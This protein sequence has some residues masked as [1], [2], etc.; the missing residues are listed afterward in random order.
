LQ[1]AWLRFAWSQPAISSEQNR[2]N[3]DY[4][5]PTQPGNSG[6]A[7]VNMSGSVVGVVVS[8]MST[9]ASRFPQN[10]NF[11]IQ[12]SI[13]INFLSVK[14]APS[15][16]GSM[17]GTRKPPDEV[18]D[19]A[20]KFTVHVYCQGISPKLLEVPA[21]WSCH[22]LTLRISAPNS[23]RKR[24]LDTRRERPSYKDRK[25]KIAT[26]W[27]MMVTGRRKWQCWHPSKRTNKDKMS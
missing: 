8:Q 15:R 24:R 4:D 2:L 3:F 21:L 6:G 19:I 1:A 26:P 7:L 25:S 27:A 20:K 13:V 23:M 16:Y 12:P 10:V 17:T 11:A 14:G 5:T 18:C 9:T 22:P